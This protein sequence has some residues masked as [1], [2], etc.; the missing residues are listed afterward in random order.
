[1]KTYGVLAAT[2]LGLSLTVSAASAQSVGVYVGPGGGS[3]GYT[4]GDYRENFRGP[5]Y[6]TGTRVYGYIRDYRDYDDLADRP[7]RRSTGGCGTYYYWDGENCVDARRE[8]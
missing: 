2:A 7:L 5:R 4:A 1:M 8:R 6:R 3:V